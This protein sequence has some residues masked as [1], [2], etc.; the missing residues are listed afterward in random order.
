MRHADNVSETLRPYLTQKH[1]WLKP[2]QV[3]AGQ[4]GVLWGAPSP[5]SSSSGSRQAGAG[6]MSQGGVLSTGGALDWQREVE[7]FLA[8]LPS[9][10]QDAA[11]RQGVGERRGTSDSVCVVVA[12]Q[13]LALRLSGAQG[14][15]MVPTGARVP[16]WPPQSPGF[17]GGV[18][19]RVSGGLEA[20][21]AGSASSWARVGYGCR[22]CAWGCGRALFDGWGRSFR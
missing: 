21:G 15:V 22:W 10:V 5:N 7:V 6:P 16:G 1:F 14:M 12:A 8:S 2:Q 4:R 18:P 3:S 13:Q 19:L 9:R 11:E 17:G 20:L